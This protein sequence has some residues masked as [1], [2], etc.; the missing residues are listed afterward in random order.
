LNT[1]DGIEVSSFCRVTDNSCGINGLLGRNGA[2]IRVTGL[3]NRVDGNHLTLNV[4]GI[5]VEDVGNVI[6]RNSAVH[7]GTGPADDYVIVS[8]NKVGTITSDPSTAGPWANFQ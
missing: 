1:D 7:S 6:V 3:D 2:G 4:Y 5:K 8:G